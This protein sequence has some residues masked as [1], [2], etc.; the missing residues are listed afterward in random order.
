VG[1]IGDMRGLVAEVGQ[2]GWGGA[3]EPGIRHFIEGATTR[4]QHGGDAAEADA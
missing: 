1:G 2:H 3:E 4:R